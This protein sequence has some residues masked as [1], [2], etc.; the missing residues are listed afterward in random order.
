MWGAGGQTLSAGPVLR[1]ALLSASPALL[2]P[3]SLGSSW[4]GAV[5]FQSF[6]WGSRCSGDDPFPRSIFSVLGRSQQQGETIMKMRRKVVQFSLWEEQS[7]GGWP[8]M[9][10]PRSR[11]EGK[12]LGIPAAR[13]L[14]PGLAQEGIFRVVQ[15]M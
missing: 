14:R 12:G 13:T 10:A 1:G 5:W 11:R 3:L 4:Q 7:R 9:P 15:R 2:Q 6:Q 8:G